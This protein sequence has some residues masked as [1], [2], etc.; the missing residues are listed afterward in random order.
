MADY[1]IDVFRLPT[2]VALPGRKFSPF[3]KFQIVTIY[4]FF[5]EVDPF[6]LN[7]H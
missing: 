2:A 5:I 3:V 1:Y 7:E 6:T 4:H